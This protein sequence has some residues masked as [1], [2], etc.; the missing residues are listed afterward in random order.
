MK[1]LA[2]RSSHESAGHMKHPISIFRCCRLSV[3]ATLVAINS[4]HSCDPAPGQRYSGALRSTYEYNAETSFLCAIEPPDLA[5]EMPDFDIA[6]IDELASGLQ[7]IRVGICI[8]RSVRRN[9]VVL[10]DEVGAIGPHDVLLRED[11]AR[12]NNA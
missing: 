3:S 2:K 6:A 11:N 5:I 12:G 1:Y 10:I 7:C 4:Q 8:D 9:P